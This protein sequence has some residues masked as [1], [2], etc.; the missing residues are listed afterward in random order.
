MVKLLE[1]ARPCVVGETTYSSVWTKNIPAYSPV[2]IYKGFSR[3]PVF[4]N[5]EYSGTLVTFDR[6]FQ[7]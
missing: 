4:I 1:T 5:K 2:F 7:N 6:I 3:I